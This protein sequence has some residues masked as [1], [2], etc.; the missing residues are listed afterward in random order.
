[1]LKLVD[2]EKKLIML[3]LL[4]QL[5]S[6]NSLSLGQS[7][8]IP[9]ANITVM[10]LVY[11]D[12]CFNN[13]FS[14]HSYFMPGVEVSIICRFKAASSRTR[15]ML[16]FSANRTTDELGLYKLDITS[17]EG[18]S[19]AAEDDKDSLMASCQASLISSSS[20]SCNVPGYKTTTDQVVFDSKM[21]NLCVYGFTALNFR[22]FEKNIDLCGK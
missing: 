16:T 14:K 8:S 18:V 10:G 13:S 5:L 21:S 6:L 2:M 12:V 1:M 19:C 20:E 3:L 15:E 11:C 4:L 17:V 7:S 22:P 9:T